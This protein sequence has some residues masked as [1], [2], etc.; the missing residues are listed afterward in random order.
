[1]KGQDETLKQGRRGSS[2][3]IYEAQSRSAELVD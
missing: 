1:M 3:A 2:K